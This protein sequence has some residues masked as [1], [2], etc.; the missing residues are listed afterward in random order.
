MIRGKIFVLSGPSGVGKGTIA[1]SLIKDNAL[2][3]YWA[4]S[5]TTRAKRASDNDENHYLFTNEENFKHLERIGEI[6]ESNY[7][8]NSWY[9]SSKSEIDNAIN[10]GKNILKEVEVNGAMVYK[11]LYPEAI[12]IFVKAD[13][14]DIKSRLVSRGQNTPEE[15]TDRISKAQKEMKFESEYDFS[16]INPQGNPEEA[17]GKIKQIIVDKIGI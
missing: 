8:N 9:G 4:K 12:L 1:S 10:N 2:N 16:V 3:F 14:R 6:L 7:Y 5:Y 17:I 11:K 15:I 13:M